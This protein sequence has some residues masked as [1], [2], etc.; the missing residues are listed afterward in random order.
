MIRP[1][2]LRFSLKLSDFAYTCS[3]LKITAHRPRARNETH[4]E[5]THG[6]FPSRGSRREFSFLAS[7]REG[8]LT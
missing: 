2:R 7:V 3:F 8:S 6:K 4:C 1:L 5:S